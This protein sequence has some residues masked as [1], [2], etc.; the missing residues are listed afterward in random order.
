M[1]LAPVFS[2]AVAAT[3]AFANAEAWAPNPGVLR[4]LGDGQ[5]YSEVAAAPNGAVLIHAAIDIPAPAK[6]V[7][8]V[9]TECRYAQKLIATVT[10]CRSVQGD[11]RNGWDIRET[12]TKGDFF[13][14]TIHNVTRT[15]YT[16]YSHIG[17]RK[18]G[19]DLKVEQGEWR[20]EPL[21]NGAG[22]R[23]IYV[24]LVG[25]DITAPAF[26][27]RAGLRNNTAKVLANLRR[28][29]MAAA[30]A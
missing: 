28:E 26:M 18:A 25:V 2:L 27:V 13:V 15:D 1:K 3:L 14:P 11:A 7:W 30:R 29:S 16:P 19:G 22:T 12:V 21:N 4:G 24:N 17:F 8:T 20:L 9:M 23:V 5:A 6:T 10:S